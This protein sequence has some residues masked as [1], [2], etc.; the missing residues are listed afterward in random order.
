MSLSH[1]KHIA[2]RTFRCAGLPTANFFVLTNPALLKDHTLRYPLFVKPAFEGS[3]IGINANALVH[4]VKVTL[5]F[6][7]PLPLTQLGTMGAFISMKTAPKNKREIGR[8]SCRE[9]V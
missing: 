1:N 4:G 8:A 5:P 9:R 7:I 2:K 3:S 6:F